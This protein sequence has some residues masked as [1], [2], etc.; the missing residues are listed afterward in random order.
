MTAETSPADIDRIVSA[1][2]HAADR[3]A[4]TTPVERA[5][6]LEAAA[7]ALEKA[8]D[9]L[10]TLAAK[11]THLPEQPRLRGEMVRT[12]FQLR[13]FGQVLT[14][15]EFLRAAVDHADAKWP[16]GPRPDIRRMTVP[17]GP[18]LVFTA[19]NF[20][21][22][23]S[24]AGHDTAAALA[25]GCP[26]VIKAHPGHPELSERTFE[27]L[28]R[29]LTEAGAPEGTVGIIY[30]L[31]S[32]VTA[33][34][35]PGIAAAAFTGSEAGGRALFDIANA[36][37]RPIPFY[38]ELGS[39]NPVVVTAAAVA[40]RGVEIATGYAGSFTLG[41]GQFC[42]KP[43]LLL[44]PAGHGLE[45]EL[46]AAVAAIPAQHMLNERI[47][48][49]Y[50]AGLER[51][52]EH[53][54]VAVLSDPTGSTDTPSR[55]LSASADSAG[56][57]DTPSQ[58][59][60]APAPDTAEFGP[61]L[62]R[63]NGADFLHHSESLDAECFG[64]VSLIVE[65]EG[66][67]QLRAILRELEPGLTITL[68]AEE[69]DAELVESLLPGLTALAGRLIWNGWPTG[70]TLSWAQQHGGPYPATTTPQFTSMGTAAIDRFL[71]PVAWQ[72]FPEALLPAPLRDA[73]P[74]D[75]PQRVD[76]KR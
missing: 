36:R 76:G 39:V 60:P 72:G 53:P 16:M 3:L 47:A 61:T 51:L 4:A 14:D 48:H 11:E 26:V 41:A 43:G 30:G 38:G 52:T 54:A 23:L 33:L 18:V 25:A 35:H 7:D 45:D 58:V 27:I 71:R 17:I 5:R 19:S 62:L 64:P 70:I 75:V 73:N 69:S 31:E 15:G 63:V 42:T 1:A 44:L 74:W 68:Q 46:R 55:A 24:V 8:S 10:V 34:R 32:G 59:P 9:E 57:T 49:G 50:R 2:V 67:E 37:P 56:S 29:A 28:A 20:P 66:P 21:L 65:Y 12:V 13:L 22:T 40:A 6:L